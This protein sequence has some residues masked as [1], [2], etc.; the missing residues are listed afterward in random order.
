MG[1][2]FR[3]YFSE[4]IDKYPFS[5]NVRVRLMNAIEFED[6]SIAPIKLSERLLDNQMLQ[7]NKR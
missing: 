7:N 6:S 4:N 3:N 1:K 5:I 2:L